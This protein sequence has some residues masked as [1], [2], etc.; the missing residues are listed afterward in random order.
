MFTDT[1]VAAKPPPTISFPMQRS[2]KP[3]QSKEE[4][5]NGSLTDADSFTRKAACNTDSLLNL[6]VLRYCL[7]PKIFLSIKDK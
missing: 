2:D 1:K 7:I 6:L 5:N 3:R 4:S